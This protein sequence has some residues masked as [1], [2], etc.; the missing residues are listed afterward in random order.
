LYDQRF[1]LS[2][3]ADGLAITAY[4]WSSTSPRAAIVLAH[5]LAEHALR[6]ERFAQA[7]IANAFTVYALDHRGHGASPGPRG[8]GDFGAG[9]WNALVADLAQLV[10]LAR[11]ALPDRPLALFGHSM[12]SFAA[13]QYCYDHSARIDALVLSGSSAW[14]L[15]RDGRRAAAPFEPNRPFE[16]ARTP[17]D[18]LSRD[19]VEV[20]KYIADPLCGF[21][22]QAQA[23]TT[24]IGWKEINDASG[25]ARIRSDLPVLLVA[26]DEDPINRKLEGLRLLEQRWR[27]GGVVR[28]DQHYYPGGRHEMLNEINRDLVTHE[29]LA[30]LRDALA[31]S[32]P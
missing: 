12:G 27:Q 11:A 21:E 5:G 30:W 31:G 8:L 3:G 17:Y 26:G 28:I 6:Y 16:P 2:S 18:W 29:I 13:Q 1:Q 9:G 22:T 24:G 19:P 20:D 25:P 10:E 23:R 32:A 7:L 15:A 14:E 4:R